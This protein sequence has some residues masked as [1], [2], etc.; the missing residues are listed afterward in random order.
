MPFRPQLFKI[1]L[2]C[3]A[4][5]A[6]SSDTADPNANVVVSMEVSAQP[7]TLIVG[8]ALP[9]RARARNGVGGTVANAVVRFEA[10]NGSG[11]VTPVEAVSNAAGEAQVTWTLGTRAGLQSVHVRSGAAFSIIEV[12]ARAG[13]PASLAKQSGDAQV[14]LPAAALSAQ[15]VARVTDAHGNPASS[16]S[17][18]FVVRSGGGSV[19]PASATTDAEGAARTTWTL[20]AAAGHHEL[21]ARTGALPA[22]VFRATADPAFTP[23]TIAPSSWLIPVNRQV[24]FT[25]WSATSAQPT[26]TWSVNGVVGGDATNGR[27]AGDGTYTAPGTVPASNAVR[28]RA[29][30]PQGSSLEALVTIS[31]SAGTASLRWVDLSPRVVNTTSSDSVVVLAGFIGYV[32]SLV[33]RRTNNTLLSLVPWSRDTYRLAVPAALAISGYIT[34]DLHNFVGYLESA[35]LPG[36]YNTFVNVRDVS[37]PDAQVTPLNA[38]AQR[39]DWVLNLRSDS[40]QIGQKPQLLPSFFAHAPD[41]FDFVAI[42]DNVVGF[43]NRSYMGM[44]NDVQGIGVSSFNHNPNFGGSTRLQGLISFP[45]DGYF[46][47]AELAASH[48]IGHRW[49]NFL[50]HPTMIPGVPHWPLS[51]MARDI[52]GFSLQGGVGG[53]FPFQ[54]RARGDGTH[55]LVCSTVTGVFSDLSLYLM[56]LIAPAEVQPHVVFNNQ[57][58]PLQCGSS[59]PVTTVTIADIVAAQGPR[60]PDHTQSQKAFALGTLVLS[61][62]RLLNADEMAFFSHMAARGE[63]RVELP[64]TSGFSKGMTKPFFLA[65]G[66]RATLKTKMW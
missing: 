65:T 18:E 43:A 51:S 47:M 36:R 29:T 40:I 1:L 61:R 17:V 23:L 22:A 49:I 20:G 54:V 52:M 7:G 38:N 63:A 5:A 6:C 30:S 21:E 57:Q 37:V 4:C 12:A 16:V 64:Y 59:G 8:E 60:V 42:V 13:A 31:A 26:V 10:Q 44:R 46:D 33:L 45:I 39:T 35:D 50:D 14:G 32:G 2:V 24:R 3:L 53:N 41:V 9:I 62:G 25:A 58:L 19:S 11:V 66:G 15:L 27:V 55:E 28:V 56:G 48:E 34:G